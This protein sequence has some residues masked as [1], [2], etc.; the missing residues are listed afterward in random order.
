MKKSQTIWQDICKE[1]KLSRFHILS[2]VLIFFISGF[3]GYFF[4]GSFSFIDSI[5]KSM[6]DQ[7]KNLNG[8]ELFGFILSNNARS[9]L[10]GMFLGLIAGVVPVF[11]SLFNG[12]IVGYVI[13]KVAIAEGISQAW[14][15]LPHG[16]F[17]LPAVFIALGIGLRL[18]ASIFTKEGR[19]D[20]TKGLYR[21]VLVYLFVVLPLLIIAAFIESLLISLY[22]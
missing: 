19:K 12:L 20:I 1:I 6:V 15:I 17:E 10:V 7:V 5:L 16:I 21:A 11:N 2:I 14:K 13:R 4:A 8:P 18:G 3:I 9:A 22:K